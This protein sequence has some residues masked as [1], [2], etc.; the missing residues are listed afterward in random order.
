MIWLVLL[1]LLGCQAVEP[2]HYPLDVSACDPRTTKECIS[3]GKEMILYWLKQGEEN[4]RLQTA[5]K[6]CREK[7]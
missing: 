2:P 4:E 5:M 7:L 1:L 3:V 6:F